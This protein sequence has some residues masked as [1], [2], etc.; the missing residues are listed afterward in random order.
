M[1]G[2]IS[3][4]KRHSLAEDAG[5]R[6]G[7]RLLAVNGAP[8]RDILELSY[9]AAD[10]TVTLTVASPQGE[11]RTVTLEKDPDEDLGLAFESA[12]FGAAT[13]TACSA[14]WSRCCRGCGVGCMCATMI[15]G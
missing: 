6:A 12:A 5:I 10:W 9:A 15:T 14:L 11:V 3:S 4:V 8:V 7:D 13:T 2:L 1:E